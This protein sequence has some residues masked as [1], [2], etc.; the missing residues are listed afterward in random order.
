[1]SRM[2]K[3]V[4]S[5][6]MFLTPQLFQQ[7]DRYH[8]SLLHF[9]LGAGQPFPWGLMA[10]DI[11]A[12][13]LVNGDFSLV[14][15]SGLMPDRLAVR[16]PDHDPVPEGRSVKPLFSPSLDVVEA[17]LTVPA[18][19]VQ[20]PNI[21]LD[22]NGASSRAPR[23][24]AEL[25]RAFDDPTVGLRIVANVVDGKVC[26]PVD[27]SRAVAHDIDLELLFERR[28]QQGTVVGDA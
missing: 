19:R 17:Y 7:A 9:A 26:A 16:I 24:R 8:E 28:E 21:Q 15:A 6:G 3:V 20:A 23:Y 22:R 12:E 27:S 11:D 10:L 5:E 13:R 2:D 4:W 18:V 14:R 1:M 25:V